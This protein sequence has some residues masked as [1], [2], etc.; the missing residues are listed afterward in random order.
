MPEIN[1]GAKVLLKFYF[2]YFELFY[3]FH[4][5][6][7]LDKSS[8][9]IAFDRLSAR[10]TSTYNYYADCGLGDIKYSEVYE[11]ISNSMYNEGNAVNG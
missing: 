11:E 3:L 10:C 4:N 1:G 8:D 9:D 7:S 2:K 6:N 5:I